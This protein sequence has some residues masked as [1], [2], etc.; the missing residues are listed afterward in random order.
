M[1]MRGSGYG[2]L[3]L[4]SF[5]LAAA[6]ALTQAG[7]FDKYQKMVGEDSPAELF[8]LVGEDLWKKKQ[9]PKKASLEKCDLGK[10]PGVVKGAHARLPRYFKDTG[11]VMDTESRLLH[12]MM[13]LQGRDRKSALKRPFGNAD[14]PSEMEYL[15]AYVAGQ[16]RGYRLNPGTS[17][18]KEKFSYELGEKVFFARTG[19]YDFSCASCHGEE[20]KRIRMS[21]LPVLSTPA[22][23]GPIMAT[24]PAYRVS[25]SQ[26]KTMQWRINNCYRQMRTPQ[27]VWGSELV[28]AVNTYLTV[29]GKG[30]IYRGPG[31][32]R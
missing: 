9:G 6:P 10:G 15:T 18:P 5:A 20:G 25:N 22:V 3:L 23:A 27:P 29:T 24:W 21:D 1:V 8:E 17:H 11:Q 13:T 14:K 7:K 2:V 16:S 31:T 30:A 28:N 4:T 12:C 32:K 19:L 26:M